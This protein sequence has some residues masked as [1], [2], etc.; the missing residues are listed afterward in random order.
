MRRLIT[1]TAR[2]FA[3]QPPQVPTADANQ[4]IVRQNQKSLAKEAALKKPNSA[5]KTVTDA[6]L[7]KEKKD[8]EQKDAAKEA[9][10]RPAVE[11][12]KEKCVKSPAVKTPKEQEPAPKALEEEKKTAP[13]VKK[14]EKPSADKRSDAPKKIE[15][16]KQNIRLSAKRK[17]SMEELEAK[18]LKSLKSFSARDNL[19]V[20]KPSDAE[21]AEVPHYELHVNVGR[22]WTYDELR[23]KTN[24]ELHKLWY[25][26]L[27][28]KNRLLADGAIAERITGQKINPK[29]IKKV[30][31]SMNRLSTVVKERSGLLSKYRRKLEDDY[32]EELKSKLSEE[33]KEF[34]EEQKVNPPFTYNLLRSK[35][36]AIRKGVDD[37]SYIDREV[38]LAEDK[39][40][41]HD[42]LRERYAYGRKK[43]INPENMTEEQRNKV[44]LD[45]NIFSFKNHIQQQLAENRSQISQEEVLRAHVRNW[46]VLN[47][48]QRRVVLQQ[49]NDRRSKDAKSEFVKE[50]NLLAQ[51]I[52]Y[53]E[54]QLQPPAQTSAPSAAQ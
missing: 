48:K 33:Y 10:A 28:E 15:S 20:P 23:L 32:C 9:T 22:A 29:N 31:N 26:L 49:I 14:T 7:A 25:V 27:K 4:E 3:R 35:F 37:T 17:I 43:I 42:Y 53:E 36:E 2:Y 38:K 8:S 46:A 16:E 50:I 34:Q 47:L 13:S 12:R 6:L 1:L 19:Q 21:K 40:K 18:A 41:L 5:H 11:E 45:K 51:K 30:E 54:N 44:N 39:T 24:E 52:A